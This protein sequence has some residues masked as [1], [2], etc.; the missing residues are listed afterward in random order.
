PTAHP[1]PYTTLFRSVPGEVLQRRIALIGGVGH[2]LAQAPPELVEEPQIAHT[3]ARRGQRLVPPLQQ[4][5][6]LGEGAGLFHMRGRREEE[7]RKS[8][9][10]NSSH[11][12]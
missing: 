3:L 8:T 2:P 4:P 10:L 6:G 1:F 11:V 12:S 7:D 5:L 9:R